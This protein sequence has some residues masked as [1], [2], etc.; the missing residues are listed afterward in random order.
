MKYF[1]ILSI[2][3]A[4]SY[5]AALDMDALDALGDGLDSFETFDEDAFEEEFGLE[6]DPD[7]EEEEARAEALAENEEEI[8]EANEK[9]ME[10][11]HSW[12][13]HVNE[14]DNLP[15]D[16]FEHDHTGL[17]K[18]TT[19]YAKGLL[20]IP[21][22]V[23]EA[24]ERYLDQFRFSRGDVPASYMNDGCDGASESGYVQW[25]KDNQPSL[26][27]EAWYPYKGYRQE[28][29]SSV[30]HFYQGILNLIYLTIVFNNFNSR[31]FYH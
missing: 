9:F 25:F 23:D 7:P 31:C 11:E 16:K 2:I 21:Q 24:S 29:P 4:V 8:R 28:C 13:E 18:N 22:A 12:W 10:G 6:A 27:A 3:L 20:R 5:G 26:T 19:V 1:L 17:E 14:F 15:H 30:K